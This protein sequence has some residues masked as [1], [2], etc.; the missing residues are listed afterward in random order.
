MVDENQIEGTLTEGV[1]KLKDAAGGLTGDTSTQADGKLDQLQA[2]IDP[3]AG[4]AR[5]HGLMGDLSGHD[6]DGPVPEPVVLVTS[7]LPLVTFVPPV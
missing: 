5:I 7:R 2:L 4:L 1:G 3:L 6:L